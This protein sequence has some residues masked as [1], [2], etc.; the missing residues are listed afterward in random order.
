MKKIW[1]LLI[2]I[3]FPFGV[4]SQK[5][6]LTHSGTMYDSFENPVQSSFQKELSRKYALN[7]LPALDASLYFNGSANNA[8]KKFLFTRT[9]TGVPINDIGAGKFNQLD[10]SGGFHLFAF[11]IYQTVNYK[12]ELGLS[13][14]FK[15]DGYVKVTNELFAIFDNYNKFSQSSYQNIFNNKAFNQTY[16]QLSINYREDYDEMWSFGGKVSLLDGATYS[17]INVNASTLNINRTANSFVTTFTGNYTSSFGTD[18]ITVKKALPDFKNLGFAIS[19]GTSYTSINGLYITLNIKDLGFIH[20]NKT[21]PTYSF[22]DGATITNANSA[23][24]GN[25]FGVAF[26]SIIN[27]NETNKRIYSLIHTKIDIAASKSFNNYTPIFV[28]SKSAFRS[29]GQI[30]LLN[31]YKI[32]AFNFGINSIYDLNTGLNFGS[33]LLIKSPNAEFYVG[34]EALFPSYYLAKGYLTKDENIGKTDTKGSFYIGLNVNFGR[35]MQNIDNADEIPGLNDKETG[36]VV[37]LGNKERKK[38]QKKNKQIEKR[39][40]KTNKRNN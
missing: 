25:R 29:D 40:E 22:D 1:N 37:R 31:N 28:I 36:F 39:R 7:L 4:F 24:A 33:Q 35:K 9:V 17:N 18:T 3:F 8:F 14:Q 13:F 12:R 38:L 20:W 19:G 26:G 30:G 6:A 2:I 10:V 23:D 32:N 21:T 15:E 27:N 16:W 5:I 34:S 11:K